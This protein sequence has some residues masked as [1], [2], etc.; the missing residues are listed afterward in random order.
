MGYAGEPLW[1]VTLQIGTHV[2][3]IQAACCFVMYAS[4]A[5]RAGWRCIAHI[6][7]LRQQ[8][9]LIV[10]P[11]QQPVRVRVGCDVAAA[12]K[13]GCKCCSRTSVQAQLCQVCKTG[14]CSWPGSVAS[15]T[16]ADP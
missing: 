6:H 11:P 4:K 13:A 15:G 9:L 5:S 8:M 1:K 14:Y 10:S 12:R 3:A 7:D 2:V 16:P